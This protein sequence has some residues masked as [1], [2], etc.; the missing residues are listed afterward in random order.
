MSPYNKCLSAGKL[1][2]PLKLLTMKMTIRIGINPLTWTNDDMPELG[3]DT[4]LEVCLAEGAE[5]GYE[6]FELGNKFPRDP[7][8]LGP[9]L[10]GFEL[11]LVSGWYSS[12][13]LERSAEEEIRALQAHLNLLRSLDANVMVFAETTDAVH[14]QMD[15]PVSQRPVMTE[16]Q[17][18]LFTSRL[19]QVADYLRGEGVR[20]AYHHHMGT[21]VESENDIDRMMEMTDESVGLLLDTGHLTYA[22]GDVLG[23]ARKHANRVVH[24]HCKDIRPEV[25]ARSIES[26]SSFLQS[27]LDG[28]FTVPGDGCIDY[29]AVWSVLESFNYSGW[30]V[31]EAEQDPAVAT[32]L[33]YAKMGYSH[34]ADIV[35]S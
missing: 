24:V 32:P 21:V 13:L 27:V 20:M 34:L 22:G 8:V 23:T 18:A 1:A 4:P 16:E 3:A 14:G 28:V 15:T 17:W 7:D 29:T 19:T 11:A 31:V 35:G 9:I 10:D 5:A 6:G 33:K 26:N 12:A 30:L 25:L 2:I